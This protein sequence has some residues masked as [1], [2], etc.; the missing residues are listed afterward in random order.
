MH[1]FIQ[2]GIVTF[3]QEHVLAQEIRS[4]EKLLDYMVIKNSHSKV[5]IA[6]LIV[7]I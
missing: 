7:D 6:S 1:I 3:Y 4:S 5:L 2:E